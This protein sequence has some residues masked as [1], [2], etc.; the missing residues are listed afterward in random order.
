MLY[1][2]ELLEQMQVFKLP[3]ELAN[4]AYLRLGRAEAQVA[5]VFVPYV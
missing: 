4:C 1:P 3:P 5:R 2:T